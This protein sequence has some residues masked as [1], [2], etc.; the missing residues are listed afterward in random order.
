MGQTHPAVA[1][2]LGLNV[3]VF[4]AVSFMIF[5]DVLRICRADL[6]PLCHASLR[7]R[8]IAVVCD[9]SV[10]AAFLPTQ[11]MRQAVITLKTSACS[12]FTREPEFPDGKRS[13][14][15]SLTIR[16]KDQTLTDEHSDEKSLSPSLLKLEKLTAL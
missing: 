10:T 5:H 3:G 13:V 8:D 1:E 2:E 11:C 4:T 6:Y 15:F 16:A 7:L 9:S 14:A 12:M